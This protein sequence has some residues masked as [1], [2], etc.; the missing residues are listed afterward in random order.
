MIRR[1]YDAGLTPDLI[2]WQQ[3][4]GNAGDDDPEG[5]N[6]RRDLLEVVRTFRDY[7]IGAP[8]LIA[9]CTLCGDRHQNAENARVL[10][11]AMRSAANSAPFSALTP[12]KSA[13]NTLRPLPERKRIVETGRDVGGVNHSVHEN[14]ASPRG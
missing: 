11:S 8:F 6:Y 7:E 12:T 10:A 2:L 13:T 3:G 5:R 4:E 1:L 9:L 14:R